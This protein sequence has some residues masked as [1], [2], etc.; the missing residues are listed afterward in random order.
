[1][2]DNDKDLLASLTNTQLPAVPSP[3]PSEPAEPKEVSRGEEAPGKT[4]DEVVSRETRLPADREEPAQPPAKPAEKRYL[5]R[6]IEYTAKELE[7]AGLLE[8]LAVTHSKYQHL[9]EKHLQDKE[10]AQAQPREEAP[11]VPQITNGMIAKAY[12]QA[13][14]AIVSDLVQGNLL[15][16]DLPE[17]YPRAVQTLVGQLRYAF[18]VIFSNQEKLEQLIAETS[19]TKEKVQAQVIANAYNQQLDALA[20]KDAKLYAGLKDQKIRDAFTKYLVEELGATIGQT[21]GEKAPA[22]LAKQWVAFNSDSVIEAAKSSTTEKKAAANRRLVVGEGTGSRTG[23]GETGE[24]SVL[25]R[26]IANSGKIPE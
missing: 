17:A 14:T 3:E 24:P 1:M 21:T 8:D 12:D 5:V 16:S 25:D 19:G 7:E 18:D 13:A 15:E 9:Q 6:G 26:M 22:F 23:V 4:P 20:K 10:R 11:Q 2:A